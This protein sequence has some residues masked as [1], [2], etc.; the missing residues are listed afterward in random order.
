MSAKRSAVSVLLVGMAVVIAAC[1]AG[2]ST[3]EQDGSSDGSAVSSTSIATSGKL[4]QD[5]CQ[6]V[7]TFGEALYYTEGGWGNHMGN[8]EYNED[9]AG[10]V[11]APFEA[12]QWATKE[13]LRVTPPAYREGV[14]RQLDYVN[15]YVDMLSRF[16]F[17]L[18]TIIVNA[19]PVEL[20]F[21]T[22]WGSNSYF[23]DETGQTAIS[24][25]FVELFRA[26]CADTEAE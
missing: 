5:F 18:Q 25:K 9:M 22:E 7:K 24:P 23:D 4:D 16:D 17:D 12:L 20:D 2:T 3:S 15:S 13:L 14:Q 19:T 21:L 26:E 8:L 11:K 6:V 1:G 10:S